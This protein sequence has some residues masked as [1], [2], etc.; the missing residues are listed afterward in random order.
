MS[1]SFQGPDTD[2]AAPRAI[3]PA[4]LERAGVEL[5]A[6]LGRYHQSVAT[7]P[8]LSR[9]RPGDVLNALP[10]QPPERGSE[11]WSAIL[12]DLDHVV[13][14][15]LTHWQH[16]AFYG[17]FPANASTPGILGELASAGLGVQGMLWATSPACTELEMRMLDWMAGALALP[18]TLTF[19]S[20]SGGGVIQGTASEATLVALVAARRRTLARAGLLD[21]P[22][23]DRPDLALYMSSQ[24]HS[25]VMKAAMVAGLADGPDDLAN[26]R[27]IPVDDSLALRPDALRRA[28]ATD[29]ASGHL[30]CFICATVGTTAS[31]AFDPLDDIAQAAADAGFTGWLHADAAHAGVACIC[32]EFRWMLRGIDRFDSLCLNPHKWLLTNFD[33]D[34]FYTSDRRA[35]VDAL[36][37]TPEYLRNAASESGAVVDYRDWQIPLGRRFRALK[38]WFVVRRFGLAGL[39]DHVRLGVRL[40]EWLESRIVADDRFEL[41]APRRLSLVCFRLRARAGESPAQTDARTRALMDRLN[42]SG[43]LYL[44]HAVLPHGDGAR[45]VLRMA[46]GGSM[47]RQ[48]HVERAWAAIGTE[49]ARE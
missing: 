11:D 2:N 24:A 7:R 26:V 46:I 21:A 17:F 19:R 15:G 36:S 9:A 1:D 8:V 41:C 13:T 28:I 18:D 40:A 16:P 39:R 47:T 10:A 23:R 32:P 38:L 25:S 14:P 22:R 37:I 35:L 20:P 42:A 30:P 29:L 5:L 45:L 4:E 6:W 49:T 33:C 31:L 27:P 34:L 48:E 44:T 12:S 43:A 3:D